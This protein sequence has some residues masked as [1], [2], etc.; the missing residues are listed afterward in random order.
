M[1]RCS[2]LAFALVLTF[3]VEAAAKDPWL[4]NPSSHF[5]LLFH[6]TKKAESSGLGIASW[7]VAPSIVDNPTLWMLVVGPAYKAENWSVEVMGGAVLNGAARTPLI[8]IRAE[9]TGLSPFYT[10]ANVEWGAPQDGSTSW[11]Y[12]YLQLD[13]TAKVDGLVALVGVETENM[14]QQ[15]PDDYSF[16]PHVFFPLGNAVFQT[17]YQFH[18]AAPGQLW[19]R[20]LVNF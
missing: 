6:G 20:M 2:W 1:R 12:S 10:W 4:R 7:V 13:Y 11:F 3:A 19:F 18:E 14:I 15:G 16:G 5:R 17:V 9:Y 8:D